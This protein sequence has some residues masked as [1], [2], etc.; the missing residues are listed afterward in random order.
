M[1][2]VVIDAL[3]EA[4]YEDR[5]AI[6]FRGNNIALQAKHRKK[7]KDQCRMQIKVPHDLHKI[8]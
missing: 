7:R 1:R 5:R 4:I 6:S 2:A 8:N 3:N